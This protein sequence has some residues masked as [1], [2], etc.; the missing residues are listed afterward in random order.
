[1]TCSHELLCLCYRGVAKAGKK[2]KLGGSLK[3]PKAA[4][5]EKQAAEISETLI[6]DPK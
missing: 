2:Q 1:M 4:E 5:P 3:D 6:Q